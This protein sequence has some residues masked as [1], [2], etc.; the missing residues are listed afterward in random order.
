MFGDTWRRLDGKIS[1]IHHEAISITVLDS[2]DDISSTGI[3]EL[4]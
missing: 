3:E 2:E 1:K 4:N